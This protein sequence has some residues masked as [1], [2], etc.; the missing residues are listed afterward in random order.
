MDSNEVALIL[1]A[2][3]ASLASIIYSMKHIRRSNCC[4]NTCEQAIPD[5]PNTPRTRSRSKASIVMAPIPE[6]RIHQPSP[7]PP[8][9]IPIGQPTIWD[10][11]RPK[12]KDPDPISTE[13]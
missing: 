1:S 8:I 12:P 7:Q 10:Y 6:E 3:A 13:V 4:G 5:L 9:P 11:L 2:V